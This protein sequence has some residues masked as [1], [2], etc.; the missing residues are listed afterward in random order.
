MHC[1][2]II[3]A[4]KERSLVLSKIGN[5]RRFDPVNILGLRPVNKRRR[6]KEK[7]SRLRLYEMRVLKYYVENKAQLE[8]WK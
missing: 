2:G 3:V 1:N 5:M 4:F 6:Y 7:V 8:T